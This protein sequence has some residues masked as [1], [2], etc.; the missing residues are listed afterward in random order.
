MFCGLSAWP[1]VRGEQRDASGS[2][3]VSLGGSGWGRAALVTSDWRAGIFPAG[4]G[5][6]GPV[7]VR[8]LCGILQA[9]NVRLIVCALHCLGEE[10]RDSSGL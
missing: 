7:L 1:L 6:R 5:K 2:K 3:A 4:G 9:L 10:A 8:W